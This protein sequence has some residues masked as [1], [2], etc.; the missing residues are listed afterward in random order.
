MSQIITQRPSIGF[1]N[2]EDAI[3][4]TALISFSV[5]LEKD[6]Q[7]SGDLQFKNWGMNNNVPGYSFFD[8]PR[9]AIG[10]SLQ[11]KVTRQTL[12]DGRIS[13]I[14]ASFSS[15]APP[16]LGLSIIIDWVPVSPGP[17]RL[18]YPLELLEFNVKEIRVS[19]KPTSLSGGRRCLI[20]T[21]I[22]SFM[23]QLVPGL[24][25]DLEG[26]GSRYSSAYTLTEVI[27]NFSLDRGL[28]TEF[29]AQL[30]G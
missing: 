4:S 9:L 5:K 13:A 7:G 21:G 28:Q 25:V 11:I 24:T 3:V 14:N 29:T 1:D 30:I 2:Q 19:R 20:G 23:G 27:H 6:G 26:L 12:V 22:A 10:K 18:S 16:A 17:V 15:N 8:D